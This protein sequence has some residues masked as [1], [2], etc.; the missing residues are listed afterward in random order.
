VRVARTVTRGVRVYT[1]SVVLGPTHPICS[2]IYGSTGATHFDQLAKILIGYEIT[3]ARSSGILIRK[4]FL[5]LLP[6]PRLDVD[7]LFP[8]LD[9]NFLMLMEPYESN[10]KPEN[11][12]YP[13]GVDLTEGDGP[14]AKPQEAPIILQAPPTI[15][16]EETA[17]PD[18]PKEAE[19]SV[20]K[21]VA[22]AGA[23]GAATECGKCI[24]QG[25]LELLATCINCMETVDE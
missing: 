17:M 4:C 8:L 20:A 15:E 18:Q 2:M 21:E 25:G 9:K 23:K 14:K 11:R 24:C 5:L 12:E 19:R 7:W 6:L 16:M 22:L 1:C 10:G 3:G 13:K